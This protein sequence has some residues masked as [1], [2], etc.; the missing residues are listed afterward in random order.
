M[1]PKLD[2]TTTIAAAA[3]AVVAGVASAQTAAGAMAWWNGT[4]ETG[5]RG[6]S[7][8]LASRVVEA[9]GAYEAYMTAAAAMR[10]DYADGAAVAAAL[11][12]GAAYEPRQMQEGA[13]AYAALAA[14]Q[15]PVFV[16]GV[17]DAARTPAEADRLAEA[18]LAEPWNV[19]SIR[20]AEHGA[21]VVAAALKEQGEAVHA[22]GRRV[23]QSAYDVQRQGW[24]KQT[25][26]DRS[27]RL[28]RSKAL[29]A[30]RY[31]PTA[32]DAERLLARISDVRTARFGGGQGDF[33]PTV[34]RGLALAALTVLG[35]AGEADAAAL[36]PLM[37][38][39]SGAS[40]LRMAKLNLFQCLA[41]AGPH[42]E[43]V[44]CLGQ[45][46]LMDTGQCVAKAAGGQSPLTTAAA[47]S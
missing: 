46:A 5:A 9:A 34:T 28:A 44:F 14:L 47:G 20:G 18:L 41:V 39:P 25:V 23:K 45:H 10:P 40:C 33:T 35:R 36:T 30:A 8:P 2:V 21:G 16:R 38:E 24:S 3:F 11:K 37:S 19:T 22:A 6:V 7:A 43:D 27:G 32:Q 29:S 13:V 1:F 4:I 15:D 42:Y 12:T 17:K 31:T 26:A